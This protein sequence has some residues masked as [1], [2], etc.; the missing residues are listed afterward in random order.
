MA[1]GAKRLEEE[2]HKLNLQWSDLFIFSLY[3]PVESVLSLVD[4][5]F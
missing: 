1:R 4:F 5:V 3:S 2:E